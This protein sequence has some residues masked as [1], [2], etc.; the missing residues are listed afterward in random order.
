[1][2]SQGEVI[3]T[4]EVLNQSAEFLSFRT[5]YRLAGSTFSTTSTL[6]FPSRQHIESLMARAGLVTREVFGDW[7]ANAFDEELS[8][9]LIFVAETSE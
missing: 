9:E 1:V 3:E 4:P 7:V 8:R 6:R 5:R 2:L